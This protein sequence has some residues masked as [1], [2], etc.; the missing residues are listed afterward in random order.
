[1][2][3]KI[4]PQKA[5]FDDEKMKENKFEIKVKREMQIQNNNPPKK[6][7]ALYKHEAELSK[8]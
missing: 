1:M 5:C 3:Q 6:S 7:G 4:S 8:S 2:S